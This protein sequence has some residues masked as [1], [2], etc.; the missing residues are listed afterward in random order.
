[1][2]QKGCLALDRPNCFCID[3]QIILLSGL[4]GLKQ[5]ELNKTHPVGL[6]SFIL[7]GRDGLIYDFEMYKGKEAFPDASLGVAGK[8]VM[9]L[10]ETVIKS[11]TL[12]F[13]RWF[14]SVPLVK[15]LVKK[16]VFSTRHLRAVDA[17]G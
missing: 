5:Y 7:A 12:Y 14:S 3:E 15:E 9:K 10:S 2:V 6:K 11:S 16:Q 8:S 17:V 4:S 1:M 13:D